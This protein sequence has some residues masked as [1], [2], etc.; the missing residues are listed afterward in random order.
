M[1]LFVLEGVQNIIGNGG[2]AGYQNILLSSQCFH[3]P[4][5]F[6]K[7]RNCVPK[8]KKNNITKTFP[9]H[10]LSIKS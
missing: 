3:E 5:S 10:Y 8:G 7:T 2:N 4:F 9:K 1:L 6:V